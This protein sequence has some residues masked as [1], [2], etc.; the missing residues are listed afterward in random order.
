M[1]DKNP[2]AVRIK[3]VF[4]SEHAALLENLSASLRLACE[5][6]SD[7][8]AGVHLKQLREVLVEAIALYKQGAGQ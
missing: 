6:G 4:L 7:E 1:S 8:A 5:R 3:R 2:D